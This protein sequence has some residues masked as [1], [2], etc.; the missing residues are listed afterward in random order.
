MRL[1]ELSRSMSSSICR[2]G[3]FTN[4]LR[5]KTA[6]LMLTFFS[7]PTIMKIRQ[8]SLSQSMERRN[9]SESRQCAGISG[10]AKF[11]QP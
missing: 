9:C 1:I 11:R 8:I 4:W 6:K 10:Y 3:D 5:R 7:T 2:H